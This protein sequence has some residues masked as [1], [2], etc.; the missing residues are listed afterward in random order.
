M[1]IDLIGIIGYTVLVNSGFDTPKNF[2]E[3]NPKLGHGAPQKDSPGVLGRRSFKL[4][5]F[6]V[7]RMRSAEHVARMGE[8]RRVYRVLVGET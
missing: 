3:I 8:R 7:R 2:S 4:H 5:R 6:V 1:A